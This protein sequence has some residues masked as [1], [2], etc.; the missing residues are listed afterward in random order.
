MEVWYR[1]RFGE[2]EEVA[3][4]KSTEKTVVLGSGRSARIDTDWQWYRKE[5][6]QVKLAMVAQYQEEAND[7]RKK[8]AYAEEKVAKALKS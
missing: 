1:A 5:R 2:I 8:L 7:F 3:V 4:E 6:E